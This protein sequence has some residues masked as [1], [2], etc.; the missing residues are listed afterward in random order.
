[1]HSAGR[2]RECPYIEVNG[3]GEERT[4][5]SYDWEMWESRVAMGLV[6]G[7]ARAGDEIVMQ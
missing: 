2:R 4:L 6:R 3:W 1:M 7:A 5:Q